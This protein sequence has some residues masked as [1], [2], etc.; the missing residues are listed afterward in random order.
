ML[1]VSPSVTTVPVFSPSSVATRSAWAVRVALSKALANSGAST[2]FFT[3]DAVRDSTADPTPAARSWSR[4]LTR[5]GAAIESIAPFTS[6][7]RPVV[8]HRGGDLVGHLL[9]D[10]GLHLGRGG[11]GGDPADEGVGVGDGAS[12]PGRDDRDGY[13]Q[14]GEDEQHDAADPAG[15]CGHAG[16]LPSSGR[17]VAPYG[18]M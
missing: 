18:S 9:L 2:T 16:S 3:T 14:G 17:V 1:T 12:R 5:S 7:R 4:F 6:G 15:A 13:E 8:D 11:D 10:E